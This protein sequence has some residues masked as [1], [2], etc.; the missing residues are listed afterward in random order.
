MV[1][2]NKSYQTLS[3]LLMTCQESNTIQKGSCHNKIS[4]RPQSRM[5]SVNFISSKKREKEGGGGEGSLQCILI[6][7]GRHNPLE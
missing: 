1:N 5:L 6:I 7:K 3:A 4:V 2:N